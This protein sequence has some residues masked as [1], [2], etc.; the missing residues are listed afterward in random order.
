MRDAFVNK[1]KKLAKSSFGPALIL[2]L[3]VTPVALAGITFSGTAITGDASFANITGVAAA[4]IDLGA[5]NTLSLQTTSNGAILTGTG[6][7]TVAGNLLANG[8]STL[9][10]TTIATLRVTGTSTLTGA[11]TLSG[12]ATLSS[13]A[14]ISG[15]ATLSGGVNVGGGSTI[16]KW[17]STT[18]SLDF[19][20]IASSS[21]TTV[22]ATVAGA[23]TTDSVV[24]TPTP[25][26]SG[27]DTA[28]TTW[29]AWVS[30][31]STTAVRACNVTTSTSIDVAAQT[32]RFEIWQH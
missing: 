14:A 2:F 1:L 7:F 12:A 20:A 8:T 26:A 10:T 3:G 32:W 31:A 27:I 28:S 17:I 6:L 15:V 4:T 22:T 13:T 9:A 19:P 11:T 29:S 16:L 21:C 5:G 24:A 25:V 30:A 23:S 18:S